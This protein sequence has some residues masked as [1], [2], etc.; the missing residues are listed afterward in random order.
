MRCFSN[1]DVLYFK[2]RVAEMEILE[3][4]IEITDRLQADYKVWLDQEIDRKIDEIDAL[5]RARKKLR[6]AESHKDLLQTAAVKADYETWR[7]V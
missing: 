4:P 3:I 1:E 2:M 5:Q 6:A 7:I